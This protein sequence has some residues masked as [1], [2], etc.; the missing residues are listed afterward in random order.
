MQVPVNPQKCLLHRVFGFR[1]VAQHAIAKVVH[2]VLIQIKQLGEGVM[3]PE[4]G[5][6]YPVKDYGVLL[7]HLPS[8]L[9]PLSRIAFIFRGQGRVGQ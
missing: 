2:R 7:R 3:I 8:Y 9:S 4:F 1:A 6:F 5:F